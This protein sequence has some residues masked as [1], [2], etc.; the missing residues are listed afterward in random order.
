MLER[1]IG[2]ARAIASF[3]IEHEGYE[4]LP[5]PTQETSREQWL[6]S[7]FM[8]VLFRAK[9]DKVNAELVQRANE[10]RKLYVSGTQWDGAPAARF[11]VANWQVNVDRDLKLVKSVL[12][13]VLRP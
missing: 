9:D 2:L 6:S 8:I 7:I 11:A 5:K 12:D 13:K 1:Q 10:T 3:I 4:L